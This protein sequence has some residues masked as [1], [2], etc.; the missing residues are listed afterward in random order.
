MQPIRLFCRQEKEEET[1]HIL[2][3]GHSLGA[4]MMGKAARLFLYD[5]ISLTLVMIRGKCT[6]VM[7]TFICENHIKIIKIMNCVEKRKF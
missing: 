6:L 5:H 4:H 2:V 3:T 7:I 1:L